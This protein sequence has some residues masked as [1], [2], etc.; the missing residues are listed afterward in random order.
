VLRITISFNADAATLVL[1]GKLLEPWLADLQMAV[2]RARDFSP[3]LHLDLASLTFA[4]AP[5]ERALVSLLREGA[6]LIACTS[7]VAELLQVGLNHDDA[8]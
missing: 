7:F 8:D 6:E 1:E 2:A 3:I 4:D 5:G